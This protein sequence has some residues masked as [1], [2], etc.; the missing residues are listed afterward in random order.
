M[1]YSIPRYTPRVLFPSIRPCH[2][3]KFWRSS[4]RTS[5]CSVCPL[6]PPIPEKRQLPPDPPFLLP[7]SLRHPGIVRRPRPPALVPCASLSLLSPPFSFRRRPFS[8][9]KGAQRGEGELRWRRRKAAETSLRSTGTGE[10]SW[11]ELRRQ[12][13]LKEYQI[14]HLHVG[15]LVHR[16]AIPQCEKRRRG[17]GEGGRRTEGGGCTM[18]SW[19]EEGRR[20]GGGGRN[21]GRRKTQRKEGRKEERRPVR[22]SFPESRPPSPRFREILQFLVLQKVRRLQLFN[23]VTSCHLG[24][25]DLQSPVGR[26][27]V[28]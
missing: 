19:K 27:Q 6:S 26:P 8:R 3:V 2:H 7:F 5:E 1:Q 22:S 14:S 23:L 9:T 21:G 4:D 25:P 11:D 15:S 17:E 20:G 12:E 28:A 16:E 24:S 18:E 13:R 10:P